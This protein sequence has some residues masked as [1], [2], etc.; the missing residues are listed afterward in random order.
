MY[1]VLWAEIYGWIDKMPEFIK[2][3]YEYTADY[4]RIKES[5]ENWFARARTARK[6]TPEALAGL[7]ADDMLIMADEASG[8]PDE[9]FESAKSAL[10]NENTLFMMISNP[11]RLE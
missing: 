2:N 9:I 10:T 5:S 11:T 1:D 6:E 4:V 8:V 3:Y 7:H